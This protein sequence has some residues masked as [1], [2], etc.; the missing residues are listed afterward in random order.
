[1][2][3]IALKPAVENRQARELKGSPEQIVRQLVEVL[4]QEAK[5]I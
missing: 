3:I 5:V 4:R 2:E 1:M